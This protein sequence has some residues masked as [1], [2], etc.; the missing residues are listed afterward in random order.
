V[1]FGAKRLSISAIA[2]FLCALSSGRSAAQAPPGPL[3]GTPPADGSSASPA[4]RPAPDAPRIRNLAGTWRLNRDDSDDPKR[5]LQQGRGAGRGPAGGRGGRGRLSEED[6]EK[7]RNFVE[8]AGELNIVGK[9]PEIEIRDDRDRKVTAF[10]DGRKLEKSK[11]PNAQRFDAKWDDYRLVMEGKD[12][13]GG[14]YER[15]YEVLAGN[16]QLRETL[17]LKIGRNQAEVSIHYVYDLVA[18]RSS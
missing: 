15:S 8:P 17:L 2:V 1:S 4:T 6:R 10:T 5:K 9:G 13:R 11:D 16:R 7:M 12:P 3:P 14:K 18:R